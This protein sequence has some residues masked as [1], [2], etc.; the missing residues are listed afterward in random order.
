[1]KY[2]VAVVVLAVITCAPPLA[3]ADAQQDYLGEL[4]HNGAG[5]R[6]PSRALELADNICKDLHHGMMPED[7]VNKEFFKTR[8]Q[9]HVIIDAAQRH[10][11][12]D[13]LGH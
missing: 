7:V 12:P 1:V 5:Y 9:A 2:Q 6:T 3:H 13:T 11:C 10:I 4:A 8:P